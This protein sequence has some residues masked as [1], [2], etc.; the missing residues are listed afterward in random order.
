MVGRFALFMFAGLLCLQLPVP[1]QAAGIAFTGIGLVLG[2]RA[3]RRVLAAGMRGSLVVALSLGLGMGTLMLLLQLAMV[4]VWPA[5][6]ELQECRAK[7][8]TLKAE[9]ECQDAYEQW[10]S[11]R[12][13]MLGSPGGSGG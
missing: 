12:T 11:D 10:F 13:Q 9:Q 1:W 5:T 6:M 3:L 4:A 7:A 2:V 8:L